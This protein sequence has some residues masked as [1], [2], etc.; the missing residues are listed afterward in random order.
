MTRALVVIFSLFGFLA[1]L[2]NLGSNLLDGVKGLVW[3]VDI[4]RGLVYPMVDSAVDRF[5]PEAWGR[6]GTELIDLFFVVFF[7]R[8]IVLSYFLRDILAANGAPPNAF[9]DPR[10][11]GIYIDNFLER[12]WFPLFLTAFYWLQAYIVREVLGIPITFMQVLL[13]WGVASGL[14]GLLTGHYNTLPRWILYPYIQ[15]RVHFTGLNPVPSL[16]T[17]YHLWLLYI[18]LPGIVELNARADTALPFVERVT[19][20]AEQLIDDL[21]AIGRDRR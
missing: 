1:A 20:A 2:S 6:P 3:L 5:V 9:F 21:A 17:R 14:K 10:F 15:Y 13:V 16:F 12:F 4:Y 19:N 8:N 7:M 11:T 18:I